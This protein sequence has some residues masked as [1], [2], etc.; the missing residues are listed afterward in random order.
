[1][2]E[3]IDEKDF[4]QYIIEAA[5]NYAWQNCSNYRC[6]EDVV[7]KSYTDVDAIQEAFLAGYKFAKEEEISKSY[8]GN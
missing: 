7:G 2:T 5:D 6:T 3:T 8:G 1:M 4:P